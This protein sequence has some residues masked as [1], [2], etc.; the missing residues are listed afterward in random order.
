[1]YSNISKTLKLTKVCSG[2]VTVTNGIV[3]GAC[4]SAPPPPPP[5]PQAPSHLRISKT[6]ISSSK[7]TASFSFTA[8]G[9]TSYQCALA[10]KPKK[11][12]KAPKLSFKSCKS[13]KSYSHLKKGKYEFEVRGE[14]ATGTDPHPASKS[15]KI[16]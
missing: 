7:H 3:G 16:S 12:H 10:A 11:G 4:G 2:T 5:P 14:N 8:T 13:P 6:K 1:L 15:F 9:A